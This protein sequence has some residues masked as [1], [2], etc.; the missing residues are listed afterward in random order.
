MKAQIKQKL[1]E[2]GIKNLQQFGYELVDKD[3]ILTDMVYSAFFLSMLK[4]NL[5]VDA[6]AD[7]A[8]KELIHQIAGL[9][10]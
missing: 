9:P 3:N 10:E 6:R 8:I 2:A 7:E 5:G 4:D 1:I